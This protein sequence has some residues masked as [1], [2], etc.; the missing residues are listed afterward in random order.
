[1]FANKES[2][3]TAP[4]SIGNTSKRTHV[5]AR[6]FASGLGLLT[7][8][9]GLAGFGGWI[10]NEPLLRDFAD[11]YARMKSN[12]GLGLIGAGLALFAFTALPLK[13]VAG[14]VLRRGGAALAGI[15][16]LLTLIQYLAGVDFG[17]DQL[18]VSDPGTTADLHP[19]RMPRAAAAGL[20]LFGLA[21]IFSPRTPRWSYW[22][23]FTCTAIGFWAS[24]F[25][26]VAYMFDAHSF[27]TFA[28]FA[29]FSLYAAISFLMLF[30]GVMLAL[31][32]RGWA[33]I[34]T[35]DK[36]GGVMARRL[37]PLMAV[38]PLGILW[39]TH[40]G[41]ELGYYPDRLGEYMGAV[42]LLIVLT[43]VV[44]VACSRL[45]VLDAHR[46]KVEEERQRAHA[47]ALRMRE[48]A[49]T[50]ALTELA[51][52]R[53]FLSVAEEKMELGRD[54]G[55]PVALLMLDI[56]HFKGI[57]DTYGHAAGD[58]ALRLLGAT[59]R[60]STRKADCAARLGGEEFAILLPG[61][62]P[63]VALA[64][65]ERICEQ[66]AKLAVLD[67]TGRQFGYTVSIGLASLAPG[68]T[69]PEDLLA[70]ADA[71]LYRAKRG[72]RNR[73]ECADPV[74]RHAA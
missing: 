51:N 20:V 39:L 43:T 46:R 12:A 55:S 59:L 13:S 72:G 17:I 24:L 23:G 4:A 28:S 9:L 26:I 25:A 57:N 50:D 1:V 58:Q 54:L 62:T 42:A 6:K 69:R 18:L 44:L 38:L 71:A 67:G 2:T 7:A 3:L 14:L 61:A 5:L 31:P 15:I 32:D 64:I 56:D 35:T 52:R 53:R 11:S 33:R 41:A 29:R 45:N 70:R 66:V 22:T 37:L 74:E 16:G 47:D 36:L 49:D 21:V 60:E 19:G 73:V 40:K 34:V 10:V 63:L 30:T 48:I 8:A 68:D 27:E 65:A